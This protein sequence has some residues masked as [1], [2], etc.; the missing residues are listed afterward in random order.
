VATIKK[1]VHPHTLPGVHPGLQERLRE[2]EE[3]ENRGETPRSLEGAQKVLRPTPEVGSAARKAQVRTIGLVDPAYRAA[4]DG[5]AAIAQ[6]DAFKPGQSLDQLWDTLNE[7]DKIKAGATERFRL[8]LES[9]LRITAMPW[10][11]PH[12]LG[13]RLDARG[14]KRANDNLRAEIDAYGYLLAPDSYGL[15]TRFVDETH[16]L[17]ELCLRV[18]AVQGIDT[19]AVHDILRDLVHKLLYQELCSRRRAMGDRGI[20]RICGNIALAD[21]LYD[22]LKQLPEFSPRE[23]LVMRIIHVHQDLGH[24]AYA[25]RVSF[26]GSKLHRAYGARIFND[27]L[28]RYRVLLT[29]EELELT[30]SAI[31]THSSEELPFTQMRLLALVRAV[32]HLAPFAPYKVYKHFETVPHATDYLDDLLERARAGNLEKHAAAK[33]ALRQLL[34][35]AELHPGL[36][37]DLMAAFRPL[38]AKAELVELGAWGGDVAQLRYDANGDGAVH[39]LLQPDDFCCRYQ[40]L[41]DQQQEQL[42]RLAHSFELS[43]EAFCNSTTLRF[44]RSG[45][46]ALILE[47]P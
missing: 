42:L 20:R 6:Q 36:R 4:Q 19:A 8:E 21:I 14:L 26:R 39:M 31:A 17:I 29:H 18:R 45:L 24:T 9:S 34:S 25:A 30:R 2:A 27:E 7:A 10:T 28:N 11:A 40:A 22:Q 43:D 33:D 37:D 35:E 13:G 3:A 41:F 1:S 15:L 23:R 46:G 16:K 38:G 44:Q 5:L 32:D 12:K 47:R